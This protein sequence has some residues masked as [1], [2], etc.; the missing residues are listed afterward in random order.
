MVTIFVTKKK[1]EVT[2]EAAGG[3]LYVMLSSFIFV[4]TLCFEQ[5]SQ[6]RTNKYDNAAR[7]LCLPTDGVQAQKQWA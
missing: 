3:R 4:L 6:E 5:C 7:P 1:Q 2:K